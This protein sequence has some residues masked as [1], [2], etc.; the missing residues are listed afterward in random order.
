MSPPQQPFIPPDLTS[1]QI[2]TRKPLILCDADEVLLRFMASFELFL[3]HQN[4]YYAWRSYALDG[5]ILSK[6]DNTII[7]KPEINQLID[8]F[9]SQHIDKIP[10]VSGAPA[11]LNALAKRATI[12]VITNIPKK[13]HQARQQ[14]LNKGGIPY[15]VLCNTGPKGPLIASIAK[16]QKAP[17]YFVDDSSR[18]HASVKKEVSDVV[19]IQFIAEPRLAIMTERCK[20]CDYRI[21]S[22]SSVQFVI[23][24]S[25]TI[26][27][28]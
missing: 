4:L 24:N 8:N 9:Y 20:N 28:Y 15:P 10:I 18:H 25:L 5:N 19:R 2:D 21:D 23:E 7:S 13:F 14:Q 26:K 3:H 1:V 12:I 17:I 6:K 22:W 27:G 16:T 11:A